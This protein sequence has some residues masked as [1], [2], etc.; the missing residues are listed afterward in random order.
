MGSA[1]SPAI[2]GRLGASF[3]RKL[4]E[5]FPVFKGTPTDN[6]WW[7]QMERRGHDP[8]LGHGRVLVSDEDGLRAC[9][10]WVHVDD[11]FVHAPTKA[12]LI[13]GLNRF[14]DMAVDVG[15]LCNPKKVVPPAQIVKYCGFLYDSVNIPTL[16]IPEDK[17]TRALAIVQYCPSKR[18]SKQ[19]SLFVVGCRHRHFAVISG[20]DTL[21]DR[22]DI[23][24]TSPQHVTQRGVGA[25][26][27]TVEPV[28]KI[29][30]VCGT[31]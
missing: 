30:P 26:I 27:G 6:T 7:S 31:R 28:P 15:L 12:K 18:Q 16:S 11:F 14:M 22:S 29:L 1:N 4:R 9:L 8:T 10:M 2:A 24:A 21:Q 20:C 19:V 17:R 13:E 3:L 5:R 23:S 25:G